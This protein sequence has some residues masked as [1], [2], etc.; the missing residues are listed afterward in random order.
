VTG[1]AAG[2][3]IMFDEMMDAIHHLEQAT[4]GWYSWLCPYWA[5]RKKNRVSVYA[6]PGAGDWGIMGTGIQI[7]LRRE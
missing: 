3:R 4:R 2:M 7:E 1:F 5:G 6:C